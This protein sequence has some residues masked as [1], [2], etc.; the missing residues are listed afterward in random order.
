MSNKKTSKN[1]KKESFMSKYGI[2]F[3][4]V[5]LL[6]IFLIV[7]LATKDS[8]GSKKSTEETLVTM[9]VSD[10]QNTIKEDEVHVTVMAQ[11]TCSWCN[12]FKPIVQEVAEEEGI[13][14]IWFDLDT[15]ATEE[16]YNNLTGTFE[17]LASFGTPYT[18]F[19]KNNEIIGEISGYVEKDELL[20]KLKEYG[21]IK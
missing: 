19:T 12:Q 16:E 9:S 21:A 7:V 10:W 13:K 1:T 18:I 11:T 3:V 6:A 4:I 14:F 2:F 15:L 20:S 17:Q 8:E 5:G